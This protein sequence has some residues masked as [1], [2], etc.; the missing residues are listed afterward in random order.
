MSDLIIKGEDF[1]TQRTEYFCISVCFSYAIQKAWGLLHRRTRE[2]RTFILSSWHEK[3]GQGHM[4]ATSHSTSK[5]KL[6]PSARPCKHYKQCTW[7]SFPTFNHGHF[8]HILDT[9]IRAV[10]SGATSPR[11]RRL[12]VSMTCTRT[13]FTEPN[14]C[15]WYHNYLWLW[16]LNGYYAIFI[17]PLLQIR[18][19][20]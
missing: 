18:S 15:V 16:R 20:H 17:R 1:I 7:L 5:W 3:M 2:N 11:Q 14:A 10:R 12:G 19:R 13:H 8:T 6:L 9:S 4:A